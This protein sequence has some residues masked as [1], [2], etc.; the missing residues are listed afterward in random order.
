MV[1]ARCIIKNTRLHHVVSVDKFVMKEDCIQR[2]KCVKKDDRYEGGD[3]RPR[4]E[5]NSAYELTGCPFYIGRSN[6]NIPLKAH[7]H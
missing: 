1:S 6:Q 4:G 7:E 5:K 3:N 2:K